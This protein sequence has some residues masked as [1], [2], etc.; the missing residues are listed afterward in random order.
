[1]SL[2]SRRRVLAFGLGGAALLGLGGGLSWLTMG[3]RVGPDDVPVALSTKEMAVVRALVD[4][5]FP[6]EGAFPSGVALGVH[7][8]ID[9]EVWSSPAHVQS[10]LKAAIQLLEHLPPA[11]GYPGRLSSLPTE[12]RRACFLDL[13]AAGPQ[14]VARAAQ[15]LK[16][17]SHLFYYAADE[18][19]GAIGYDGPWVSTPRPPP[20]SQA[21]AAAVA[22]R[23]SP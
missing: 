14:T 21:Y 18:A 3:Y 1:M 2:L 20:S 19:W 9:E 23:R 15:A 6:A 12:Q 5:L 13:L 16:Q 10:D 7:Q 11:Y 17:L 22:A 8:R 4:C